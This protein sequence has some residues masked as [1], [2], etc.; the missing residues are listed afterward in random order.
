MFLKVDCVL[1]EEVLLDY[2]LLRRNCIK[3]VHVLLESKSNGRMCLTIAQ[4]LCKGM[5]YVRV[6]LKM[7]ISCRKMRT[8]L[9]GAYSYIRWTN[10]VGEHVLQDIFYRWKYFKEI[11]PISG[12]IL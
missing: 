4:V 5:S 11:P 8:C 7:D 6:C 2:M 10:H 3:C 12:H 9:L 1:R